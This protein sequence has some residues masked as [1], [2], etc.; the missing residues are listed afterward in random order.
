MA[1]CKATTLKNWRCH[2][3]AQPGVDGLCAVHRRQS[4][5]YRSRQSDVPVLGSESPRLWERTLKL[6][7]SAFERF[8]G[9]IPAAAICVAGL[10]LDAKSAFVGGASVGFAVLALICL[11]RIWPMSSM[12]DVGGIAFTSIVMGVIAAALAL[13]AGWF[14]V[15]VLLW[16]ADR[17]LA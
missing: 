13:G 11:L 8:W 12:L 7:E 17:L 15:S 6:T 3:A 1:R 2:L 5:R 9:L 14:F 16:I 4:E 10:S